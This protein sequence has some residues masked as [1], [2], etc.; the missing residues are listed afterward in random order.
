MRSRAR[1]LGLRSATAL[2]YRDL[3]RDGVPGC[4]SRRAYPGWAAPCVSQYPETAHRR[5]RTN[6]GD[7]NGDQ[8]RTRVSTHGGISTKSTTQHHEKS[9]SI[10]EEQAACLAE[11]T[12]PEFKFSS[13]N[14]I[15]PLRQECTR[16]GRVEPQNL[17]LAR[18]RSWLQEPRL[19]SRMICATCRRWPC[20]AIATVVA[21]ARSILRL[22]PRLRSLRLGGRIFRT[23]QTRS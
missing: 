21:A 9:P 7:H 6:A 3:S 22:W 1:D 14:P 2:R 23:G 12:A 20:E 5:H 18:R 15:K 11:K 13:L 19:L 4:A 10:V 8:S 16:S 17:R